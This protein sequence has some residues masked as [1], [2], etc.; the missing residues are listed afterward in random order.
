MEDVFKFLLVAAVMVIGLVRQFK[1][2]ARKDTEGKPFMLPG[3]NM[4][5]DT[6]PP[7]PEQEDTYGGYIPEG[8]RTTE[9]PAEGIFARPAKSNPKNL[10]PLHILPCKPTPPL[11]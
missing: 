11:R 5:D 3:T 7:Y 1:K 6:C 2:E 9:Q 4:D 8:P 10:Q